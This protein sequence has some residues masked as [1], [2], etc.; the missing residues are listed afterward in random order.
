V[1][2][3]LLDDHL[4]EQRESL[5]YRNTWRETRSSSSNADG[6]D[7]EFIGLGSN[8]EHDKSGAQ[9]VAFIFPFDFL[10]NFHPTVEKN[11]WWTYKKAV[12]VFFQ[13]TLLHLKKIQKLKHLQI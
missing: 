7:K 2:L 1:L 12:H 9:K 3:P 13:C 4:S 5:D 8:Q 10:T 6:K 11:A